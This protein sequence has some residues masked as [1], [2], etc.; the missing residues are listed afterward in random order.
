MWVDQRRPAGTA[1][2]ELTL[3][4]PQGSE[5]TL[6]PRSSREAVPAKGLKDVIILVVLIL[7]KQKTA[8]ERGAWVLMP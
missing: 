6:Q 7:R 3:P 8:E 2:A 4:K 5:T 1:G